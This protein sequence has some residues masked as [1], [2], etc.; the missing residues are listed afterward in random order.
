VTSGLTELIP[1]GLVIGSTHELE[2]DALR[3]EIEISVVPLVDFDALRRV[4]VIV[5]APDQAGGQ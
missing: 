1:A 4:T 2:R 3:N 5:G